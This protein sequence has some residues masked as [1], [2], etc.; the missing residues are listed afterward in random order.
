M[1][2]SG[3]S[4]RGIVT[5]PTGTGEQ[6]ALVS[7]IIRAKACSMVARARP[8]LEDGFMKPRIT[9]IT[10]GVD[11]LERAVTFYNRGLGLKTEGI[12]GKGVRA[13]RGCVLRTGRRP[14]IGAVAAEEFVTRLRLGGFCAESD[15]FLSCSQC[16]F[17]SGSR[18][19]DGS[20]LE[21]RRDDRQVGARYVLR[22]LR[23]LFPGS[24]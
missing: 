22:W 12:V 19:G 14:A 18:C 13:R 20:G 16:D 3:H 9:L 15:G 11:D 21:C 10:L 2:D 1:A 4:A 23:R 8:T 7:G 6:L 5:A 17:E 24:G